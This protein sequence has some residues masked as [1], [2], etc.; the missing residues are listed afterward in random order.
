MSFITYA[1]NFEDVIL[2]RAL[3]YI[4]NGFY[5]DVG[6][7]DPV[8]HSV[9]K[10][11]YDA[12]WSG[13]NIEPLPA[14]HEIFERQRPRDINLAVAAGAADGEVTLFDVPAVNGWAS[15]DAEV[16]AGHRAHGYQVAELRLPQLSLSTIC[17]Q[18]VHGEVHFLKIDVE[19]FEGEVLRGMDFQRWRPWVLVI[20][21]TMPNSR[22]TNHQGWESLV[23]SQQYEFAYFDGLNRYYVAAEHR[24]LG[25][26][27]ALQPNVFDDFIPWQLARASEGATLQE[28]AR[29]A[30]SDAHAFTREQLRAASATL[31]DEQALHALTRAA[32][33]GAYG[34]HEVL[35]QALLEAQAATATT[36]EQQQQDRRA[37]DAARAALSEEYAAHAATRHAQQQDRLAL[38][39]THGALN[40]EHAAHA[41]TRVALEN[42]YTAHAATRTAH[43]D[44]ERASAH[45]TDHRREYIDA[46][47]TLTAEAQRRHVELEQMLAAASAYAHKLE[48]DWLSTSTW[49]LSLERQVLEMRNNRYWRLTAP[50][51]TV[52]ASGVKGLADAVRAWQG[53][54]VTWLVSR[55]RLRRLILPRLAQ[56]PWLSARVSRAVN[57]MRCTPP[58]PPPHAR[59]T[60]VPPQLINLPASARQVLA[61]LRR[62]T[63]SKKP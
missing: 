32:L 44:D 5:I 16:A 36:R 59:Q 35:H 45:G 58:P 61:D 2:W 33:H 55:E 3:G 15:S 47:N 11:F 50:L 60:D 48:T 37:L 1:Q 52:G 53:R 62:I 27:M 8:E 38:D 51:R 54:T 7:N 20:E 43:Q 17:A 21:A 26:V 42:E 39:A 19:G 49:A 9:T 24:A 57:Q 30:E 12:G 31:Q 46:V 14:F 29:Q 40:A 23:T 25:A 63:L 34:A 28:A 6:A 13:I 4:R 22:V 41:L 18:H 56:M 10:A